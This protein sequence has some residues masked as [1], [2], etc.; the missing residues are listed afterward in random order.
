MDAEELDNYNS[1]VLQAIAFNNPKY[2]KRWKWATADKAGTR[3]VGS[4]NGLKD[5]IG[6]AASMTGGKMTTG[7]DMM[8][9]ARVTGRPVIYLAPDGS[10]EDMEG[11]LVERTKDAIVVRKPELKQ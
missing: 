4:G 7:G 9:Y 5:L 2:L 11:N 6:L 10:F 1:A 3:S 8:E